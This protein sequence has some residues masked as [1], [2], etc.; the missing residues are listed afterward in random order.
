MLT[1]AGAENAAGQFDGYKPM[2][3][4]AALVLAPDVIIVADHAVKM[5]GGIEAFRARPEIAMTP[6]GKSGRIVAM[7]ALLLLGFGPRTPDALTALATAL[8]TRR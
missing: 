4:E 8:H 2:T 5:L 6:A 1:L 7:D 3:P